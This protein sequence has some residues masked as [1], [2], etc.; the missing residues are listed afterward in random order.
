[1]RDQDLRLH[2]EALDGEEPSEQ[3]VDELWARVRRERSPSLE[4]LDRDDEGEPPLTDVLSDTNPSRTT[5]LVV[6][7][8]AAAAVV[9]VILSFGFLGGADSATDVDV[10]TEPAPAVPEPTVEPAR[11]SAVQVADAWLGAIVDNDPESFRALHAHDARVSQSLMGWN[12]PLPRDL[13]FPGQADAYF[14][15]FDAFQASIS[16]D[17]DDLVAE[18]CEESGAIARC[19]FTV[20]LIGPDLRPTVSYDVAVTVTD[21]LVSSVSITARES[22]TGMWSRLV[23]GFFGEEGEATAE[24]RACFEIGWNSVECGAHES[25]MVRR[26]LAVY[27]AELLD[28][29]DG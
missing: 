9:L 19:H 3:F 7:A 13:T 1:M 16:A 21:G 29:V 25:E 15:G 8:V 10:S 11:G 14:G 20:S 17:G 6:L 2:L 23:D 4:I 5:G 28:P 24:D 18:G 22:P 26:Y 27:H 12:Q